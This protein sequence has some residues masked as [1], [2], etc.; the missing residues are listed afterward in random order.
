MR[1]PILIKYY[2]D[3]YVLLMRQMCQNYS[4][5]LSESHDSY[6]MGQCYKRLRLQT[7]KMDYVKVHSIKPSQFLEYLA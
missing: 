2:D 5:F 4:L 1:R 3:A 6:I 7:N